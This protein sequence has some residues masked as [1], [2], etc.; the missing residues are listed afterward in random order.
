MEGAHADL[1]LNT[2]EVQTSAL[3]LSLP[4][5]RRLQNGLPLLALDDPL[6]TMDELTVI[7]LG[8]AL[9][10]LRI[11]Y[12]VDWSELAFFHGEENIARIRDEAPCHIYHLP[13][14][15]TAAVGEAPIEPLS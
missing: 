14:L 1:L 4:L 12:P 13:W 8:R 11:F 2:A 5:A 3:L 9:A 7:T 10:K 6:Q 15:Q